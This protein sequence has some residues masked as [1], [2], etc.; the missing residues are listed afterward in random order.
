MRFCRA[1]LLPAALVFACLLTACTAAGK[2]DWTPDR[3][4]VQMTESGKVTETV[5]ETLDKSYYNASELSAM[6]TDEI[7]AYTAEHGDGTVTQDSISVEGDDVKL[8]LS[9]A[10]GD[11]YAAFN[12]IS[13]FNGSM[14]DAQMAG[15]T[16][17][18][19]FYSVTDGKT[20][21][22]EISSEEPLSHKEYTVLVT[23]DFSHAVNVPGKIEYVSAGAR[24]IDSYT[25]E[26]ADVSPDYF[27]VI[28]DY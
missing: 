12:G 24:M 10:S 9:Y 5:F 3:T 20:G 8:V 6:I 1:G 13:F 27:Y 18:G 4:A 7:S 26:P 22:E 16:F 23:D 17:D 19:Y 15:Y 14:L 11:D 21:G 28:Y 25:A 2:N